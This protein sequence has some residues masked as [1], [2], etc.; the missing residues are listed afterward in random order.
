LNGS[1]G[2]FSASYIFMSGSL[3]LSAVLTVIAIRERRS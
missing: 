3:F 2:G 1:T